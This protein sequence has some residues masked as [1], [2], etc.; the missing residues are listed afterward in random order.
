MNVKYVNGFDLSAEKFHEASIK[1]FKHDKIHPILMELMALLPDVKKRVDL[2]KVHEEWYAKNQNQKQNESKNKK[3]N[4]NKK[5][6]NTNT[7]THNINSKKEESTDNEDETI[8]TSKI[9]DKKEDNLR[10]SDEYPSLMGSNFQPPPGLMAANAY[11]GRIQ[12]KLTDDDFPELERKSTPP[13]R[14]IHAASTPTLYV[15]Y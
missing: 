12:G 2:K 6:K 14:A 5:N 11:G 13:S 9:E 10:E 15:S 3:K 8:F 4:K 7:N 1:L